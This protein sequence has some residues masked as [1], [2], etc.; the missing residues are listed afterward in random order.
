MPQ[1]EAFPLTVFMMVT[2]KRNLQVR[3]TKT[4]PLACD[5]LFVPPNIAEA[6]NVAVH[7]VSSFSPV[8]RGQS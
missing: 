7:A 6:I 4:P 5:K 3:M 1:L 2:F 8:R